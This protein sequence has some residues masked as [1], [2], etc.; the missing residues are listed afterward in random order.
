MQLKGS[1]GPPGGE[2]AG[3]AGH[4]GAG[5]R[6]L[7]RAGAK[8]QRRAWNR[9]GTPGGSGTPCSC[10]AA[11]PRCT[12]LTRVGARGRR[13]PPLPAAPAAGS[14][15]RGAGRPPRCRSTGATG[16]AAAGLA[17]GRELPRAG[18]R[19]R[20]RPG[21]GIPRGSRAGLTRRAEPRA[22]GRSVGAGRRH[23]RLPFKAPPPTETRVPLKARGGCAGRFMNGAT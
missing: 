14:E 10:C 1:V 3:A 2:D 17:P 7:L 23:R 5:S 19:R 20:H 21:S 16:A 18:G 6:A 15:A 12:P 9:G 22:C 13:P 4:A 11:V 8:L